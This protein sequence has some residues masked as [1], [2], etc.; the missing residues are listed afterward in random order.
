M[1]IFGNIGNAVTGLKVM[2]RLKQA[3]AARTLLTALITLAGAI[4]TG[5]MAKFTSACPN[6]WSNAGA[7]VTAGVGGAFAYWQ[8]RGQNAKETIVYGIAAAGLASMAVQVKLLC[9]PDFFTVLPT[10]ATAGAWVGMLAWLNSPK[11]A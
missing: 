9:G 2:K 3:A 1:G 11:P 8:S 6:L 7:I 10:I 4:V 5:V